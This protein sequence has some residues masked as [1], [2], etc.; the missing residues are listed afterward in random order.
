MRL[1]FF[2]PDQAQRTRIFTVEYG[3][4]IAL[5]VKAKPDRPQCIFRT[6]SF[7]PPVRRSPRNGGCLGTWAHSRQL[8][9]VKIR[10]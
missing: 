10:W 8:A 2:A 9:R 7:L 5:A 3:G 4:E 6:I 1:R